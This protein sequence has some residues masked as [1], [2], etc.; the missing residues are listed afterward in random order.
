M[1]TSPLE[2]HD[3]ELHRI[4]HSL[5]HVLAQ[6]V[7]ELRPGSKLGFGP[8]ID[9]GFYYDFILSA[10]VNEDDFTDIERRMRKIIR[11]GQRFERDELD[12]GRGWRAST[13]WASPTSGS[14]PRNFLPKKASK[15]SRF[16]A[17]ALSSTCARVP[18]SRRP[19]TCPR[20][21]SRFA[22]WPALTGEAT[23]R[24]R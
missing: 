13:K 17:T 24:T 14:T 6:A 4:R 19:R 22:P 1:V 21:A 9:D 12:K 18:T 3:D 10:P 15:N 23:R 2:K 7:L 20:T 11:Q 8:A 5:A 16:T